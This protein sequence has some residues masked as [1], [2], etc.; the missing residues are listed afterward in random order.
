LRAI[1]DHRKVSRVV[2]QITGILKGKNLKMAGT[3]RSIIIFG[4]RYKAS[5]TRD[6]K[7]Q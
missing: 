5:I 6:G 2:G 1:D 3:F 4:G 7:E